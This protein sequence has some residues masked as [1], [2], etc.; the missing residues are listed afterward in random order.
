MLCWYARSSEQ[1]NIWRRDMVPVK[2]WLQW[3]PR[4]HQ[5]WNLLLGLKNRKLLCGTFPFFHLCPQ[6]PQY[7]KAPQPELRL[8]SQHPCEVGKCCYH[9]FTDGELGHREI[10]ITLSEM[11]IQEEVCGREGDVWLQFLVPGW[12]SNT[13]ATSSAS[14]CSA[15]CLTNLPISPGQQGMENAYAFYKQHFQPSKNGKGYQ[16]QTLFAFRKPN[17]NKEN[18]FQN[19]QHYPGIVGKGRKTYQVF[20][21][22]K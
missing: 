10:K 6:L 8:S 9:R 1:E 3:K 11:I 19:S 21:V 22:A 13:P 16:M 2:P 17:P 5:C 7:P 12:Y 14:R 18:N 20:K 15:F 4:S